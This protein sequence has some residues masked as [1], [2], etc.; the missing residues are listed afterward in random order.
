[1]PDISIGSHLFAPD[2]LA[3]VLA[4]T[5]PAPKPGQRGQVVGTVDSSGAKVALVMTPGDGH[6]QIEAAFT[7][8]WT[9]DNEVGGRVIYSF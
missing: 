9:G 5:V 7:H 3:R 2:Q 8:D 4:E 1:M 6:W